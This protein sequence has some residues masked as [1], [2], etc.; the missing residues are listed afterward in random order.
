MRS[1]FRM[2]DELPDKGYR[3]KRNKV[4]ILEFVFVSDFSLRREVDDFSEDLHN[5]FCA[6]NSSGNWFFLVKNTLPTSVLGENI[7]RKEIVFFR[8]QT[9][10]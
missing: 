7:L 5:H 4:I 1:G 2:E 3:T 8:V 6:R 9:R 10:H